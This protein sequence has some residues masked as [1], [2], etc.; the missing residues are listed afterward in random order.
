MPS[1]AAICRIDSPCSRRSRIFALS[2]VC[3]LPRTFPLRFARSN[4]ALVRSWIRIFS[5]RANAA[6]IEMMASAKIPHEEINCSVYE[7]HLIPH[8]SNRVKYSNVFR[9]PSRLNL[10]RDQNSKTSNFFRLAR[11]NTLDNPCRCSAV[12]P[13][14]Q[15]SVI[16]S[17]I[18]HPLFS[19]YSLRGMSES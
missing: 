3:G 2:I 16:I 15:T 13:P 7:C 10:S 18:S 19:A 6:M 9:L 5:C 11:E 17:T 1:S 14:E 12:V 4:P 8:E